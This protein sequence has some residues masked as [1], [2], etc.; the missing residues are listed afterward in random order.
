MDYAPSAL[1]IKFTTRT[2]KN[3]NVQQAN[4]NQESDVSIHAKMTN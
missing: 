1:A 2:P 3:A 4:S